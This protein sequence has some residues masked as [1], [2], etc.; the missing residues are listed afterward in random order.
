MDPL[1]PILPTRSDPAPVSALTRVERPRRDG[2]GGQEGQSDGRRRDPRSGDQVGDLELRASH[3]DL[4]DAVE[5]DVDGLAAK[6]NA[7][8]DAN[9]GAGGG[10]PRTAEEP[11]PHIDLTA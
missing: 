7:D 8:A 11:R 5:V 2:R 3:R 4:E 9:A 1:N 6:T 10:T